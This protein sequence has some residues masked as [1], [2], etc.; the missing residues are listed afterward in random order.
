MERKELKSRGPNSLSAQ[1]EN[2]ETLELIEKIKEHDRGETLII[3]R[4]TGNA[5]FSSLS[6]IAG[7]E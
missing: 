4:K 6:T 3:L 7:R 2:H 5:Q 1:K